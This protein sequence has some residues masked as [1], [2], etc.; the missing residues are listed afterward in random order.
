MSVVAYAIAY[1]L[2]SSVDDCLGYCVLEHLK[3]GVL[4]VHRG[5]AE[6][7]VQDGVF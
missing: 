1:L 5:L 2:G 6:S 7:M 3:I 4:E